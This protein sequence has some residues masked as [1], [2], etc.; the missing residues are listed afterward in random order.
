MPLV[1]RDLDNCCLLNIVHKHAYQAFGISRHQIRD[2]RDAVPGRGCRGGGPPLPPAAQATCVLWIRRNPLPP[3]AQATALRMSNERIRPR[4][5]LAVLVW[6]DA[7]EHLGR[8]LE[9]HIE[10]HAVAVP[11][12]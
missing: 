10:P 4:Y 12:I 2:P 8:A 1:C 9:D 11:Q 6:R 5:Q 3:A 7:V